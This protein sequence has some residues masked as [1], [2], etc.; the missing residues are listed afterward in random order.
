MCP[1][2]VH[3][4][5]RAWV[6]PL[7]AACLTRAVPE[8]EVIMAFRDQ[9]EESEVLHPSRWLQDEVNSEIMSNLLN[10][11]LKFLH[12]VCRQDKRLARI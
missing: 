1:W 5:A 11:K 3:T 10:V 6:V 7:V 9:L 2:E 4:V 12:T 8:E